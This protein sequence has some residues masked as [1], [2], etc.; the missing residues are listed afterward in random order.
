MVNLGSQIES[1]RMELG[2]F[3]GGVQSAQPPPR[4]PALPREPPRMPQPQPPPTSEATTSLQERLSWLRSEVSKVVQDPRYSD[5]SAPPEVRNRLGAL[6]NELQDLRHGAEVVAAAAGGSPD[7]RRQAS[8]APGFMGQPPVVR[9]RSS[10]PLRSASAMQPV[11]GVSTAPVFVCPHVSAEFAADAAGPGGVGDLS[12]YA[13]RYSDRYI[14]R[15]RL[16]ADSSAMRGA[17]LLGETAP[18]TTPTLGRGMSTPSLGVAAP[19]SFSPAGLQQRFASA[20][21]SPARLGA[22]G[23]SDAPS[24]PS[25]MLGHGA[26]GVMAA[27]A[28]GFWRGG[29]Q[30]ATWGAQGPS[31]PTTSVSGPGTPGAG[32]QAS[33]GA[34]T[35]ALSA[36]AEE[37]AEVA[38]QGNMWRPMRSKISRP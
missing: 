24:R 34:E 9:A 32:G 12:R 20:M 8:A 16:M 7:K 2:S 1:L 28:T 11:I 3:V 30:T 36:P 10:T 22:A 25:Y 19:S 33:F 37:P 38:P 6:L 27:A 21:A 18:S 14:D 17:G 15:D 31:W 35:S 26:S 29:G 5:E 23:L 4:I 13:N